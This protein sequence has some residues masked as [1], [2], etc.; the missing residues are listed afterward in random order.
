[1]GF[2][3]PLA[4]IT[5]LTISTITAKSQGRHYDPD[6]LSEFFRERASESVANPRTGTLYGVS[7]PSNFTGMRASFV[8][9][10]SGR[11]RTRGANFSS[12]AIPPNVI[13]SPFSKRLAIV[14]EDL[15]NWSSLFY[16]VPNHSLVAP[17][18]GFAV[19]DSSPS[20]GKR[21]IS[22]A[23]R[24]RPISV[25]FRDLAKSENDTALRKCVR[26]GDDGAFV[27]EGAARGN[28][29]ATRRQGRFSI[30]V[31]S[32][33]ESESPSP[34]KRKKR[35]YLKW[36]V[37]GFGGGFVGVVLIGLVVLAIS[38]GVKRKRLRTM[39]RESE[40]GVSFGTFHV[41]SSAKLPSALTIRTQPGIEDVYV[42]G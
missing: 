39:E 12:F 18:I 34:A 20:A 1:M 36:W 27:I 41:G 9:L 28:T 32:E 25:K 7:L 17:V 38:K 42:I 23:V 30:V 24:G 19:Y 3:N 40:N 13:P 2:F 33:S 31:P 29:C 21:T 11:F 14:Y 10:R 16:A 8:R 22:L 6:S 5:L 15:G 37:I 4:I 35:R 26:F